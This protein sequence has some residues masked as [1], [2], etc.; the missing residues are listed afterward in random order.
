M[1]KQT[2]VEVAAE[3]LADTGQEVSLSRLNVMT[4]IHRAEAARIFNARE[5]RVRED[6]VVFKVIS[7]WLGNKSYC[8][9][10]G[11]P[12]ILQCEGAESEFCELV[13]AVSTD[14]N[15]YTVLFE[16]ER[17][18]SVEK[19]PRGLK[20]LTPLY[21]PR[22]LGEGFSMLGED[23]EDLISAVSQNITLA[24]KIP[25]LHIKTEYTNVPSAHRDTIREWFLKE[26]SAFHRR[27]R[28]FLSKYDRD[29]NKKL[30]PGRD[31]IRVAVCA[32]SF[33]D[34]KI[35]RKKD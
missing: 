20:L 15:P 16:M 23:T 19:T 27:A 34:D 5:V 33:V 30:L 24:P 7:R 21:T 1:L 9:T 8:N 28:S 13:R 26:G 22:D 4:G 2:L 31:A 25:N 14:L 32:F 17:I 3:E 6:H 11:H 12:R 10:H 29:T 35:P 18:G